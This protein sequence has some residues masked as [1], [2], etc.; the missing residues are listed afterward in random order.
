MWQ[1]TFWSSFYSVQIGELDSSPCCQALSTNSLRLCSL[2][3]NRSLLHFIQSGFHLHNVFL[4]LCKTSSFLVEFNHIFLVLN[5]LILSAKFDPMDLSF[6]LETLFVVPGTILLWISGLTFA[7]SSSSCSIMKGDPQGSILNVTH[8]DDP[9]IWVL[10]WVFTF[11]P[12]L[13]PPK[14]SSHSVNIFWV[15]TWFQ[16]NIWLSPPSRWVQVTEVAGQVKDCR[17]KRGGKQTHLQVIM[18]VQ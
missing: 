17:V 2:L 15:P 14:G 9:Q 6:L 1:G 12:V 3:W 4:K 13:F 11:D 7:I 5:F 18:S 10:C 16:T 8:W